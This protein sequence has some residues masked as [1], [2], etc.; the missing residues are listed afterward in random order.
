MCNTCW[1]SHSTL[2][3]GTRTASLSEKH[4]VWVLV[5]HAAQGDGDHKWKKFPVLSVLKAASI[6]HILWGIIWILEHS[7]RKFSWCSTHFSKFD[8]GTN[9]HWSQRSLASLCIQLDIAWSLFLLLYIFPAQRVPFTQHFWNLSLQKD[10]SHTLWF[11][12][13]GVA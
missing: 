7:K 11:K 2:S 13:D 12:V 4:P 10:R 6:C 3:Q 1:S 9:W 8:A 5:R